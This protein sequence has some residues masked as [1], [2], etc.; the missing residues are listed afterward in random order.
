MG[1]TWRMIYSLEGILR[2]VADLERATIKNCVLRT[3]QTVIHNF[4]NNSH[5]GE[6]FSAFL[7]LNCY[8]AYFEQEIYGWSRPYSIGSA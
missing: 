6:L 3:N 7:R 8:S 5:N 1:N 4:E 2:H